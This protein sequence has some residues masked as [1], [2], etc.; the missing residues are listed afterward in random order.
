M[1]SQAGPAHD[2][3]GASSVE[4]G[5]IAVAIAAVVVLVVFAF[6]QLTADTYADS[7][8]EIRDKASP[9]SDCS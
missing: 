9:S 5:L 8:E 3:R 6:G 7:C 4:Y 2:E 1:L